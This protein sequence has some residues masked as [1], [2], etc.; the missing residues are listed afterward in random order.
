MN[1]VG[2]K[3][4][5]LI[6]VAVSGPLFVIIILN[7]PVS[8]TFTGVVPVLE[9]FNTA[10]FTCI[11]LSGMVVVDGYSFHVAVAWLVMVV[12]ASV[13]VMVFVNVSVAVCPFVRLFIVHSRCSVVASYGWCSGRVSGW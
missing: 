9:I 5:I 2:N 4:L 3:S 10:L 13:G 6:L 12:P 11:V 7:V 1:P 8:P